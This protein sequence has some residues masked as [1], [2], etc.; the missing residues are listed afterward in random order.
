MVGRRLKQPGMLGWGAGATGVPS[1]R[2]LPPTGRFDHIWQDRA[3][4]PARKNDVLSLG[5]H[6]LPNESVVGVRPALVN[7]RLISFDPSGVL[8]GG[9]GTGS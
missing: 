8:R 4:A 7:Q 3:R 1:F 9:S 5:A 6:G 2:T